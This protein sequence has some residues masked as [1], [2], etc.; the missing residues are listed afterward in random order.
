[1]YINGG[2]IAAY[3]AAAGT[4]GL[5]IDAPVNSTNATFTLAGQDFA[6]SNIT[7]AANTTTTIAKAATG[8]QTAQ[9][10]SLTAVSS[11]TG[12]TE[13]IDTTGANIATLNIETLGT[14]KVSLAN[15]TGAAVT[16]INFTGSAGITATESAA[17]AAA[18]TTVN[19]SAATGAVSLNTTAGALAGAFKFTGGTAND[20]LTVAAG[21]VAGLISGAQLDGGAG[22]GDKIGIF[23]TALNATAT[24][25]LNQAV[26]W[27]VLGLNANITL[28]AS[29]LTSFKQFSIDTAA[30]T[31]SITTLATGSTTTITGA[32][33]TLTLG[34]A[35][36]VTDTNVVIGAATSGGLVVTSLT[37]TGITNVTLTSNGTAANSITALVNS[38]NSVFT[39]KGS[40]DL[41]MALSNGTAV[42]SK[43]DGSAATGKLTLTGSNIT[44]SGDIII[45]GTGADTLNGGKGADTL[46]GGAGADIFKFTAGTAADA[47]SGG[48]FGQPDVITDFVVGTDKLQF[49]SG[50]TT[51]VVSGQQ[52]AVQAAVTALAAGSSDTA[53]ANAMALANTTTLGVSFAVFGGNTYVLYEVAG[54]GTGVAADDA[55]IKLL[56]VTTAPTFAA[57]VTP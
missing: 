38:D 33:E 8:T 37:T 4:T 17:M 12:F 53:I 1:V 31:T 47:P 41:T 18:V 24:A 35:V 43:I 36:G 44:T 57:D 32:T 56:G 13:T 49:V 26:N 20:T 42:G 6:L 40:A 46:T 15:T 34:S 7:Q 28:D 21:S 5:T 52:G 29:T 9:K 45:G 23:D 48:T 11:A 2:A 19:A 39:L 50:A 3:T 54:A 51:D 55:F 27:E 16:T 14:S 22:T 30:L 25:R 10:I